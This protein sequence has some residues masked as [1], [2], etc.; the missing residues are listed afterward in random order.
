MDGEVAEEVRRVP[1]IAKTLSDS[2]TTL[3]DLWWTKWKLRFFSKYI[4]SISIV[5]LMFHNHNAFFY[6]R[7]YTFFSVDIGFKQ[8]TPL[9]LSTPHPHSYFNF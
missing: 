4:G 3:W 6:H 2:R 8:N 5:P 1:L 7:S 9:S